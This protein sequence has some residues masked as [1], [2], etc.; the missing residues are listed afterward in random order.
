M[1]NLV[2]SQM[3]GS[4]SP[5][6]YCCPRRISMLPS[7]LEFSTVHT[8][9]TLHIYQFQLINALCIMNGMAGQ[10][11]NWLLAFLG[12]TLS[13]LHNSSQLQEDSSSATPGSKSS[14][15]LTVDDEEVRTTRL[16]NG[17]FLHE[18]STFSVPSIAGCNISP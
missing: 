14:R 4:R 11:G 7:Q 15:I 18:R 2:R 1:A 3:R 16:R 13:L 17:F 5:Y 6:L 10:I 9:S 8:I 12:I